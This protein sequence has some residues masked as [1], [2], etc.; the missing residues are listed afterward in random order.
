MFSAWSRLKTGAAPVAPVGAAT[1]LV[2]LAL[3][4]PALA[5][6][7]LALAGMFESTATLSHLGLTVLPRYA[8]TTALLTAAVVVIVLAVGVGAAWLIAACEFPPQHLR[9]ER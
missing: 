1:V 9:L 7:V 2:A 5:L 6:A 8:A 3:A 4:A